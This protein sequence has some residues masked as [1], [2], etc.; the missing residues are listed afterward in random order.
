[1]FTTTPRSTPA[2][3]AAR[4][5][6]RRRPSAALVVSS[7]ALFTALSGG[8]YAATTIGSL[9]IKNN[10][11]QSVDVKDGTLKTA[12][13]SLSA[14]LA[15]KGKAGPAGPAG[16]PG[17]KGDQGIQGIQGIPGTAAAKGDKGDKGDQGDQGISGLVRVTDHTASDSDSPKSVTVNCP[18][19]KKVVGTGFDISGAITGASP[20]AIKSVAIDQATIAAGLGSA[21]FSGYEQ[22]ATAANWS[23][24]GY[25]MCAYAG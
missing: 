2:D 21:T 22:D 17:P 12:D 9:Q 16:L 14:R 18:A 3:A 6:R 4:K 19:G 15:L 1:M 25:V 23:V 8:A 13:M 11:V 7:L 5:A 20:N 10:A 24:Y